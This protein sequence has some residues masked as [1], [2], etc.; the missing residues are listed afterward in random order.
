MYHLIYQDIKCTNNDVTQEIE[1]A[2]QCLSEKALK[3]SSTLAMNMHRARAYRPRE[4]K[5]FGL[6]T[7][8]YLQC[9]IYKNAA[10]RRKRHVVS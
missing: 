6:E 4:D 10:Q 2:L 5:T 9:R 8:I 7:F 1:E 3:S